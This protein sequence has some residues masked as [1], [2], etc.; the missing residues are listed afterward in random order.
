M[1]ADRVA[2]R[3]TPS[4][5]RRLARWAE[6]ARLTYNWALSE[7]L[8]QYADY[9]DAHGASNDPASARPKPTQ[10][11]LVHLLTVLR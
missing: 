1:I 7:W 8:R 4:Q 5:H 2:L 9:R 6:C 10:N 3:V 11:G